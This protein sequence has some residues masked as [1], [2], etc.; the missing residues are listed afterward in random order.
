MFILTNGLMYGA[1]T[2]FGVVLWWNIIPAS[3]GNIVGG[4]GVVGTLYWYL[5][6]F[7]ENEIA[8]CRKE[9]DVEVR[10]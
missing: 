3:L 6:L 1:N 4:A 10:L 9:H 2:N 5:Y 8:C 7:D